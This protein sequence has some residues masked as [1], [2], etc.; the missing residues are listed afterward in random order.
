MH[1]GMFNKICG[2][3]PLCVNSTPL[4]TTKN[5]YRYYQ[6]SP[7]NKITSSREPQG[8]K[9]PYYEHL[10]TRVGIEHVFSF[11]SDNY[12]S[13]IARSYRFMFNLKTQQF[14][15]GWKFL[16]AVYEHSSSSTSLPTLDIVKHSTGVKCNLIMV[17]IC[18]FLMINNVEHLY[19]LIFFGGVFQGSF[20]HWLVVS[21]LQ[22]IVSYILFIFLVVSGWRVDLV[23][24]AL[25]WLEAR[26]STPVHIY[27]FLIVTII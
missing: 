14:I 26:F 19:M 27:F 3:Y 18:I 12:K 25:S 5:I 6:I 22:T 23:P 11:L 21:V 24:A 13:R 9:Q 7:G 17:L 20:F 16:T 10:S 15:C 4:V 2:L 1:C 8:N